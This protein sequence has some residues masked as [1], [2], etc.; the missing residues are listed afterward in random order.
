[1]KFTE[2]QC[3]NFAAYYEKNFGKQI[4]LFDLLTLITKWIAANLK[5]EE[6]YSE[7]QICDAMNRIWD[8]NDS[9]RKYENDPPSV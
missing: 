7:Q 4:E 1:M 3:K 9:R 6:V 5:P 2:E 8:K